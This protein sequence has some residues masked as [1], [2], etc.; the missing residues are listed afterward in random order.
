MRKAS[1][2]VLLWRCTLTASALNRVKRALQLYHLPIH[3][4]SVEVFTV[5]L[6][7]RAAAEDGG[8]GET[9]DSR[10]I[11]FAHS[12]TEP[13]RCMI[14]DYKASGPERYIVSAEM[15]TLLARVHGGTLRLRQEIVFNV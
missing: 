10:G 7:A 9:L 3:E 1:T 4:A 5:R 15:E 14:Q 6:Y 2:A 13:E 12:L 8:E 11:V